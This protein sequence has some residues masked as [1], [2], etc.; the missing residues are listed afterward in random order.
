MKAAII[1]LLLVLIGL[2]IVL[3]IS[4]GSPRVG[5]SHDEIK[6]SLVESQKQL[7]EMYRLMDQYR[8]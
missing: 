2:P 1:F 3:T 6:A 8:K 5:S 7:D 4:E